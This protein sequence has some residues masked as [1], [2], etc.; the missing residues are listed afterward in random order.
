[1]DVI[2]AASLLLQIG[3]CNEPCRGVEPCV[4]PC[5]VA[6]LD[7][8]ALMIVEACEPER[9]G[10]RRFATP[11][12]S[13][14]TCAA[15]AATVWRLEALMSVWPPDNGH[16]CGVGQVLARARWGN[17]RIGYR[18]T[19]PCTELRRPRVGFRWLVRTMWAKLYR[20][21]S[22]RCRLRAYNA[23]PLHKEAYG[24]RGAELLRR[25]GIR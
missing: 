21:R 12:I 17:M 1:V 3:Y 9:L 8:V 13:S 20:C 5:T 16:G 10:P 24:R 4:Q 18:S 23:H 6:D 14:R 15:A 2:V 7:D 25:V 19:P 22:W 11:A